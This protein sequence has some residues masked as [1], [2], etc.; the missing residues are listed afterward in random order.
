[1]CCTLESTLSVVCSPI[2]PALPRP[3]SSHVTQCTHTP[4]AVTAAHA[5]THGPTARHAPRHLFVS[6]LIAPAPERPLPATPATTG[7]SDTRPPSP[8]FGG[9][10]RRARAAGAKPVAPGG[11]TACLAVAQPV[12]A[13]APNLLFSAVC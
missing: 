11:A 8:L 4:T 3:G 10:T 12:V 5:A 9:H 6:C 7:H 1:M 13:R 2:A